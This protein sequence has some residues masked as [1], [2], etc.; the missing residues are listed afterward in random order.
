MILRGLLWLKDQQDES[1][2]IG[3]PSR[4]KWGYN[5]AIGT[6]ALCEAYGLS[7]AL[8]LR[9]PAQRAVDCLIAGQNPAPA[10]RDCGVGATRRAA[11]T[12]IS[13]SPAG[14]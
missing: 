7:R 8:Q 11:A 6:L 2:S 14:R 10:A 4:Y 13:R 9:Q 1:G 12:T 5:H 3:E